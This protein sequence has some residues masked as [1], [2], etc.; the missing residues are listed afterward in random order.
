MRCLLDTNIIIHR[1]TNRVINDGIGQLFYWLDYLG[2]KKY[3]HPIT[4]DEIGNYKN[5]KVVK[6]FKFKLQSYILIKHPIKWST[7]IRQLSDGI[8]KNV[9]DVND[10]H[11][12]NELYEESVDLLL[13]EDKKLHEKAKLLGIS[14]KVFTIQT[15][16]EKAIAENPELVDYKVLAVKKVDFGEIDLQDSFFDSF[17]DDYKEFDKWFKRKAN[18]SCYVCY[19][20]NNLV[21]FLY[22]KI[23]S[24]KENYGNI[25]PSFDKK[26]RLKIGTLKVSYN[27]YKIGERFLKIVFDNAL[28]FEV[29][30]IYVTIFKNRP[31]QIQLI[32]MLKEWGFFCHGYKSSS[33]GRELVMVRNFQKRSNINIEEP[34]KTFPFISFDTRKYMVA[35]QSEYHTELFPDSINTR[36]DITKYQSNEVHRNRIGKVYISHA[37][38]RNM[39]SGDILVIY[40][41]GE[42]SPKRH[43]STVTSICIIEEVLDGFENFEAFFNACNRRTMI[44]REDLKNNWWNKKHKSKP[45]VVKFL[46]AHALPQPKPTLNDLIDLRIVKDTSSVPR[47]FSELSREQF[48]MLCHFAY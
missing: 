47:G 28:K 41:M 10:T 38:E 25:D 31:E 26:E 18:E 44:N 43:T 7:S 6:S 1:E 27:G 9:N 29:E 20:N 42:K 46:Y 35:I 19:E 45:F 17:R 13:T 11:L 12:L 34:K 15:F 14:D 30:E 4:Q 36:E 48:R 32:D 5:E 2:Y 23:E 16:L 40:R 21:A 33:N 24:S 37:K 8:D 39:K 22:I 3:I